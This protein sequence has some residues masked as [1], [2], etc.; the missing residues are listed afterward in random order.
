L[1]GLGF[2]EHLEITPQEHKDLFLIMENGA[3]VCSTREREKL[4]E[5]K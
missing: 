5:E 2:A 3:H 1:W 4:F